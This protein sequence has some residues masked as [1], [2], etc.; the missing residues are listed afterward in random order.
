MTTENGYT[1]EL[2]G[3]RNIDMR[4][5]LPVMVAAHLFSAGSLGAAPMNNAGEQIEEVIVSASRIPQ[6]YNLDT[7]DDGE[8]PLRVERQ[9]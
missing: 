9:L 1:G 6:P 7:P 3:P 5:T 2:F 8:E 4:P